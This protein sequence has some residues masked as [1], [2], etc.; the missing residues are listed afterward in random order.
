MKTHVAHTSAHFQFGMTNIQVNKP[1]IIFC[2]AAFS[3]HHTAY[4][5][6][7]TQQC[8]SSANIEDLLELKYW[9]NK[10]ENTTADKEVTFSYKHTLEL[11]AFLQ[12]KY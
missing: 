5:L 3:I 6:T 7:A 2:D 12:A 10:A 9:K 11:L 4:L 8:L 1:S